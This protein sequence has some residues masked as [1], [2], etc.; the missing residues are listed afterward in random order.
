MLFANLPQLDQQQ[1]TMVL[2]LTSQLSTPFIL[3]VCGVHLVYFFVMWVWYRRDV[4]ALASTLD[5]FTREI[6]YRSVLDR[7]SHLCDQIEAFLSDIDEVLAKPEGHADR[8]ALAHR[9]A[10]LDE[11]RSYLHSLGFETH[12]NLCRTMIETYPLMGILGTILAIGVVLQ[13]KDAS[14]SALVLRFGEA[15]WSTFA[16][17]IA[18]I[19]LMLLNSLLET[20]FSRL[21]EDRK[22][23][24][25]TVFRVKR[26]LVLPGA[27]G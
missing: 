6:K 14:V 3:I 20:S 25:E 22:L 23:V 12:Y 19:V 24:R 27:A 26:E 2:S 8:Q 9:M 11:K 1:L 17:L 13:V 18:A 4:R 15:I 16:G 7:N 5:S 21:S 10:I